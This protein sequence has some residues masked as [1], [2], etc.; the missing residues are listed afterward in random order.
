MSDKKFSSAVYELPNPEEYIGSHKNLSKIANLTPN[1]LL[2]RQGCAVILKKISHDKYSG[3]THEKS[4]LSSLRG[5]QYAT[6]IVTIDK[7]K[8]LSWDRGF[9][10]NDEHVWGAEKGAYVFNRDN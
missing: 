10:A 6:S 9:N 8:I 7:D 2:V 3:S 4:C 1:K 5:A